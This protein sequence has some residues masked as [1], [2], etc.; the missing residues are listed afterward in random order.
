MHEG[1]WDVATTSQTKQQLQENSI[2]KCFCP[3][4]QI[5]KVAEQTTL[6]EMDFKGLHFDRGQLVLILLTFF[7]LNTV[8]HMKITLHNLYS[9]LL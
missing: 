6:A 9:K 7:F 5:C 1:T 3:N 8:S 2:L 4:V